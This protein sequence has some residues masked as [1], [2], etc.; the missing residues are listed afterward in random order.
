MCEAL[1]WV[2]CTSMS[3]GYMTS[4]TKYTNASEFKMNSFTTFFD[5]EMNGKTMTRN[6]SI[7]GRREVRI[8]LGTS[9]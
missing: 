9:K 5:R 8:M 1:T 2:V 3:G 7:I 4:R 6:E